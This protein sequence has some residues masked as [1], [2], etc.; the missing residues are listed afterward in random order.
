MDILASQMHV[1]ENYMAE[2]NWTWAFVRRQIT[3]QPITVAARSKA[4]TVFARP[5]AGI[6]GSNPTQGMDVCIVCFYSVFFLF[7]V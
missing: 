1:N 4:W 5:N 3:K 2:E 7:C 6:M